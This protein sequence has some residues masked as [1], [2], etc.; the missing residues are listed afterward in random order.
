MSGPCSSYAIEGDVTSGG[1]PHPAGYQDSGSSD[2]C[3]CHYGEP[4][5]PAECD[6]F[7]DLPAL[8]GPRTIA[9]GDADAVDVLPIDSVLLCRVREVFQVKR[10]GTFMGP[11]TGRA[12]FALGYGDR[13]WTAT[14]VAAWGPLTV[15]WPLPSAADVSRET[16]EA[17][18]HDVDSVDPRLVALGTL[19]YLVPKPGAGDTK[20]RHRGTFIQWAGDGPAD[21]NALVI[22]DVEGERVEVLEREYSVRPVR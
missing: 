7:R 21:R 8:S 1:C 3:A 10:V 14:E 9:L 5:D 2:W 13:I 20:A 15:L 18:A 19:V 17:C 4:Y 22:V 6:A 16:S 11:D 12:W